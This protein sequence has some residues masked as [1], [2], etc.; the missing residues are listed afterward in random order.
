M[1]TNELSE[2]NKRINWS[3]KTDL[4][5]I[6]HSPLHMAQSKLIETYCK[7]F[8]KT[9]ERSASTFWGGEMNVF[10]P[11]I[12]STT[13]DR[14]GFFEANLSKLFLNYVKPNMVVFDIG[15]HFGYYSKLSSWLVGDGGEVHAFDPT[16]ST[17]VML[18]KN[19][20]AL[21]N[22]FINNNAV[23]SSDSSIEILDFG[24]AYSAF[25]TIGVGNLPSDKLAE[26]TPDKFDV[27]A[28]AIDNYV[29][30]HSKIPDFIKIDAEGAE[31]EI[32]KG[33]RKTL[34]KHKPMLTLEVGD[35][36]VTD[37]EISPSRQ[38]VDFMLELNYQCFEY[39]DEQL[40]PH[41]PKETYRYDNLFFMVNG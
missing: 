17:F 29:A 1:H 22:V 32:L 36:N 39:K 3:K 18:E 19:T 7:R 31:L 16:P 24:I 21:S 12:V 26:L 37:S 23:Y 11:E 27:K 6:L 35:I 9:W 4:N 33:M 41:E 14:Y 13:I 30:E 20:K 5:K 28:I 38:L 2:L 25:N 8:D 10:L 40:T 34:K 15:S